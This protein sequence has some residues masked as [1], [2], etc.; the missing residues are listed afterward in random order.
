MREETPPELVDPLT[1]ALAVLTSLPE[2]KKFAALLIII[3]I[4]VEILLQ[5]LKFTLIYSYN[6]Q[7]FVFLKNKMMR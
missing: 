7:P 3:P 2:L 6:K 1:V 5:L 4:H